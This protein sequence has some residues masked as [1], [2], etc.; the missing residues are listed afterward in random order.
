ML[1]PLHK[2]VEEEADLDE[3][4]KMAYYKQCRREQVERNL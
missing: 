4:L 3:D 1:K 2:G